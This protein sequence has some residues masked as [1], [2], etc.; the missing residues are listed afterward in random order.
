M[1]TR[2][3]IQYHFEN[4]YYFDFYLSMGLRSAAQICQRVT[5]AVRYMCLMLQIAVLNYLDDFAGAGKPELASKAY[6]EL[7]NLLKSCGIEES[8]DKACPPST[9]MVFIRVLFNTEDI[10]LSVTPDRVQE[11]LDLV[12]FWLPKST[13]TLQELQSLIGKLSFVVS[14]VHSSRV[15]IARLLR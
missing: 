10:I 14:C 15:F 11:I 2:K 7:G 13:A 9:K 1:Y 6:E 3:K 12:N 5:N 4:S 8:K